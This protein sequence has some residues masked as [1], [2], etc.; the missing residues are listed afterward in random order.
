VPSGPTGSPTPITGPQW[1]AAQRGDTSMQ[2]G[3][4]ECVT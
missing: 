2:G 1:P 3:L 4:E